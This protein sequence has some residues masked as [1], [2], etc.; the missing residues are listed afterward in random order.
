MFS[1]GRVSSSARHCAGPVYI[2]VV[3]RRLPVISSLFCRHQGSLQQEIEEE[4]MFPHEDGTQMRAVGEFRLS[5]SKKRRAVFAIA[6]DV[7][8]RIEQRRSGVLGHKA[9]LYVGPGMGG[10]QRSDRN[11]LAGI[12]ATRRLVRLRVTIALGLNR[13]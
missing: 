8:N 1:R 2:D 9:Q 13:E 3:A 12:R 6:A 7:R 11:C 10:S 4:Q 5:G